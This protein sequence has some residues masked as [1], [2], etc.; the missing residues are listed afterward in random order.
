M[1]TAMA[2]TMSTTQDHPVSTGDLHT[3]QLAT[4]PLLFQQNKSQEYCLQEGVENDELRPCGRGSANLRARCTS[5]RRSWNHLPPLAANMDELN[6]DTTILDAGYLDAR[7]TRTYPMLQTSNT[8]KRYPSPMQFSSY[9]NSGLTTSTLTHKL[10]TGSMPNT[11]AQYQQGGLSTQNSGIV[12]VEGKVYQQELCMVSHSIP[13]LS[14]PR[15]PMW[16]R[17]PENSD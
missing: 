6:C 13:M 16:V 17:L 7:S 10:C 9:R 3:Y 14:L 11:K 4:F 12:E 15:S 5:F 1:S 2:S 8:Q